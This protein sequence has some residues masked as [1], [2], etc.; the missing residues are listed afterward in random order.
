MKLQVDGATSASTA[1]AEKGV[2]MRRAPVIVSALVV[3]SALALPGAE[4]AVPHEAHPGKVVAPAKAKIQGPLV[5]PTVHP[6]A[7][8]IDMA[9]LPI[10]KRSAA[11]IEVPIGELMPTPVKP[12]P[13]ASAAT[14]T[15]PITGGEAPAGRAAPASVQDG[16]QPNFDGIPA[17][18]RI[19]PDTVMDVGPNHI[20]QMV[21]SSF[22]IFDKDGT[23]LAGPS[24]IN[25]LWSGSGLNPCDTRNDG[26]PIVLYDHLSDRW[27]ISQFAV[28]SGFVTP[29]TFQCVAVSQTAN[30]TAGTW[31]LYQFQFAN[32]FDYPKLGLW[33]DAYYMSSQRGFPSNN[34]TPS[35]DVYALDRANMV[36]GNAVTP[37]QFTINGPSLILLPS[38]LDGP[39]P[40]AGTP[41]FFARHVDGNQWG[42]VDRVDL[43]RFQY[44][45]VTPALSTFTALPSLATQPFDSNLCGTGNLMDQCV[46]QSG[47]TQTLATLPHWAMYSLQF[48]TF[49][50]FDRMVFN[51]TVDADGTGHAAPKWY[52]LQRAAGAGA[53]AIAQEGV[54]APDNGSPGLGDDLWRWMGSIA[55]N[56]QGEIALGYSTSSGTTFPSVALTSRDPGDP[57]GMM[58]NGE[59]I[60]QPGGGSQTP[61]TCGSGPCGHRWGDYSAMRI[62]PVDNCT[63][64]YTQ[65]YIPSTSP[66]NINWR[67][68]IAAFEL[69]GC[70]PTISVNDVSKNEGNAGNTQFT[71]T[72]SLSDVSGVPVTVDYQTSDGSATAA[73]NDYQAVGGTVTFAPGDTSEPVTVNV[74][75]ENKFEPDEDFFVNLSN[76][77]NGTIDDGQGRGLILNDDPIPAFSINDVTGEEGNFGPTNFIFTVSLS[78][79]SY[80]AIAVDYVTAD[81]TATVADIDYQPTAGT[82][83]LAPEETSENVRVV[84][85]GDTAIELDETFFINLSNPQSNPEPDA[86]I[87]DG[88]GR[89]TIVND[90]LDPNAACTIT[91]TNKDDHLVGTPGN[92]VICGRNGNDLIEGMGGNDVLI[93][94]NGQD[95]L[96]GGDGNDLLLGGNGQNTMEGGNGNDSLHGGNGEDTLTGGPGSDALFGENGRDSL[97]TRDGVAGNDLADGGSGPDV[98]ATDPTDGRVSC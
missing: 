15:G 35:L 88:Q 5:L 14:A 84:V 76:P 2:G 60:L 98:C 54:F 62:D 97:N 52:E 41:A 13:G 8:K 53:W 93:G 44:N 33:P 92:D 40:P 29:P 73:D 80:Q 48:R 43:F 18:N 12:A 34:T 3:L 17:T 77:T 45:A 78:N 31:N 75:G 39:A 72:V 11:R 19:P 96:I 70:A 9:R 23:S 38:D 24:L 28:P 56:D 61:I 42:G 68:R 85:N 16:A 64:W 87:A 71:F 37:V 79:P 10:V 74:V 7:V 82:V 36:A 46:P 63:F 89:G 32:G 26:D 91:G 83:T 65:E 1:Q 69:P 49:G 90:D 59:V 95:H 27:L 55:Q 67:T 94:G 20:V 81:G 51:H 47:T 66:G 6:V 58:P 57:A 25:T 21:N 22:Q 86:T 50:G 30:P 4:G